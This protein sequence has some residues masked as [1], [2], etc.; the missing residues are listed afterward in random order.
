[1]AKQSSLAKL[2]LLCTQITSP[3]LRQL[4]KLAKD[5]EDMHLPQPALST[6]SRDFFKR[7]L[8]IYL[9]KALQESQLDLA[10]YQVPQRIQ[11]RLD[12]LIGQISLPTFTIQLS[13]KEWKSMA[14]VFTYAALRS[15][16]DPEHQDESL[17][18]LAKA[19]KLD[20]EEMQMFESLAV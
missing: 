5:Q 3:G 10:V 13:D 17:E 1:M 20:D 15:Q 12:L 19:I 18:L 11:R 4:A 6:A 8:S 9:D 7:Q 14:K 2:L 16:V